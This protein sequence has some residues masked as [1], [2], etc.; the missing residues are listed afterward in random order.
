MEMIISDIRAVAESMFL[1]GN[2]TFLAMVVAAALIGV[3][4]MRN[5][6]QILCVSVLSMVALGAIWLIY[7]GATSEAPTAPETWMTQLESGWASIGAT[8][9]ATMVGYLVVFAA[10]IAVLFI[11]KSIISRG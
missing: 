3:M 1:G 8:S 5:L 4:A 2:W 10:V 11:G 7:G 6:G 9:G